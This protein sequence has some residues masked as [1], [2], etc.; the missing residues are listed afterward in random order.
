MLAETLQDYAISTAKR[1]ENEIAGSVHLLV[2]IR[3][4]REERFDSEFPDLSLRLEALLGSLRGTANSVSG[5]EAPVRAKLADVSDEKQVWL[6]AKDLLSAIEPQMKYVAANAAASQ[7]NAPTVA[8][9]P[10]GS[11]A[12]ALPLL[13]N[14]GLVERISAATGWAVDEASTRV[15]AD[16][17]C[18]AAQVLGVASPDIWSQISSLSGISGAPSNVPQ[19]ISSL[20]AE[21][22]ESL[23]DNSARLATQLA[24]ALVD[25]GEWAAA[26]DE[27]VTAE[28]TDRIDGIR[29]T[30]R[31]LLNGRID[32]QSDAMVEFEEKFSQLVGM[33]LVKQDLRKRVDF[34]VVNKKREK[35][36]RSVDPQRMHMAFLGNPGTGKTSVARLYAELLMNVGLLPTNKIVETD[37]S[38]LVGEYIGHTEKKTLGVVQDA[39]GGL[40]FIDEAYALNDRYHTTKGFGEEATDILVKQMEDRRESLVVILAGY[41]QPML[42][43]IGTNPGLRS[44][45]PALIDF[46]DYSLDELVEIMHR[47]ADRKGIIVSGAAE[48]Q[49]RLVLG[50]IRTHEG[51]GN[52]REVENLLEA[53]QRN[54]TARMN[55]LGNLATEAES[56]TIL[57]EDIPG[58]V[59][60]QKRNPIGFAR[61]TSL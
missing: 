54:V 49:M 45:I 37:R 46:P 24:L 7:A 9:A 39:E 27:L 38:G 8:Q 30:L 44:R 5:L 57:A 60:P 2:A 41:K 47:V 43:Y 26:M 29:L 32:A 12:E 52:A 51:F 3:R 6:L 59:V 31:G 42:D 40:L 18:V 28:E 33:E 36:G 23:A 50:E 13:L 61:P 11:A 4:W 21:V 56:H 15:L 25:V 53:A 48:Q 1:N 22:A 14:A 34:L 35:R 10:S 58:D 20:V 19:E 16:A 55:A 17:C